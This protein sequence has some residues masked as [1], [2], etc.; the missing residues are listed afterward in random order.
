MFIRNQI[1]KQIDA[2]NEQF[3]IDLLQIRFGVISGKSHYMKKSTWNF[4]KDLFKE[5]IPKNPDKRNH[6]D[7]VLGNVVAEEVN[8]DTVLLLKGRKVANVK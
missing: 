3:G 8:D 5:Y 2:V 4:I 6:A 1:D 7:H